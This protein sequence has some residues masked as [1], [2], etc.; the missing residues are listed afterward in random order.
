MLTQ[1][2]HQ[3]FHMSVQKYKYCACPKPGPGFPTSYVMV[4]LCST[5]LVEMRGDFSFCWYLWYWW[6]SLFK[7]TF[8]N[9]TLRQMYFCHQ[10]TMIIKC[11]LHNLLSSKG[12]VVDR[13]CLSNTIRQSVKGFSSTNDSKTKQTQSSHQQ[14][15]NETKN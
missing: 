12:N 14:Y 8:H 1:I 10:Q 15:K 3:I 9:I 6:A 7:L 11:F 4:L 5:S 13:S 2:N